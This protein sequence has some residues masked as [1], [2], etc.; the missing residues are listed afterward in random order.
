MPTPDR[1]VLPGGPEIARVVCG[2]WQV[3]DIEKAG[4]VVDPDQGADALEAYVRDGFDTF[5]MADH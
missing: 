4:A 2:L 1:T 3:A 5:D